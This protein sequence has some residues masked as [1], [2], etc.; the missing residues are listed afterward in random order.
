MY[1]RLATS[2]SNLPSTLSKDAKVKINRIIE[3]DEEESKKQAIK[4]RIERL[5]EAIQRLEEELTYLET[6]ISP[7]SRLEK[8]G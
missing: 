7:E 8:A 6:G 2:Y 1:Y 3:E 5:T 4:E